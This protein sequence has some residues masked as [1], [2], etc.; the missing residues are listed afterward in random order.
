MA[1]LYSTRRGSF[2]GRG[3]NRV[4]GFGVRR[5]L[6]SVEVKPE[7]FRRHLA[8]KHALWVPNFSRMQDVPLERLDAIAEVLIRDAGRLS[9]AGSASSRPR[10]P[11]P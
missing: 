9:E 6:R 7:D 4:L 1:K 8:D 2:V 11:C 5:G 10:T 3:L